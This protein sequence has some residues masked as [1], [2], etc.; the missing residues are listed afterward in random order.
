MENTLQEHLPTQASQPET[1]GYVV[2]VLD[3]E[4]LTH[5]VKRFTLERPAGFTFIPG[6]ATDLSI[7]LPGLQ[8]ELRPFTITSM[9]SNDHLEFIIKIYKGHNGI[10]EKLEH[11]TAGDELILHEVFGTLTYK[12]PG[13]FIAGGAGITP[14]IAI[15]RHLQAQNQLGSNTLLF[16]NR[17]VEDIILSDELRQMLG[18]NYRDILEISNNPALPGGF[19]N[20]SILAQYVEPENQYYYI[21]GPDKFVSIITDHLRGLGVRK[22]QL[23]IEE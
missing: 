4:M 10:T 7:N 1:E 16:A 8:D 17:S 12:G 21:C 23:I 14:F 5:N 13:V 19:I 6:Q 3:T 22:S 15:F 18:G 9:N 11:I 2:K 20:H